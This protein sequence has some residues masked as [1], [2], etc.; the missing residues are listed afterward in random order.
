MSL[1]DLAL[2]MLRLGALSFGGGLAVLAEMKREI[3]DVRGV[4]SAADFAHTYALGQL[5]PGPGMLYLIPL[6]FRAAGAAGAV[7]AVIGFL[8]PPVVLQLL[9]AGQ[10]ARLRKN[11]WIRAANRG[12]VPIS[13][14]L[15]GAGLLTLATPLLGEPIAIVGVVIA[16]IAATRI[17]VSPTVIVLGAG[18][19][20]VIGL[21]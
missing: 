13:L 14:G 18:A 17:R 5:T 7:V 10:W 20:G 12:F 19:L 16:A 11:R 21:F 8:A 6:G 9:L 3:V 1:P 15:V 4:M 2:L